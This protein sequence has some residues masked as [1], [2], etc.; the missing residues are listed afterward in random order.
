MTAKDIMTKDIKVVS[1]RTTL[2]E[3]AQ[4][5]ETR[6]I[7]MVPVAED[8]NVLGILTDR[9]IV[10]RAISK[11]KNPDT[12][13]TEDIMSKEIER[14]FEDQDAEEVAEK[15]EKMQIR[16]M[17]VFD[18]NNKLVGIISLG[19]FSIRYGTDKACEMLREISKPSHSL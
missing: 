17:P 9:D 2:H 8:S 18:R 15:M 1:P 3:A 13:K 19:D 4:I 12:I 14:C 16:R 5:M 11:G 6:N 7:G 10:V